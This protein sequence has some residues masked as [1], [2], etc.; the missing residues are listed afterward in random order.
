MDISRRSFLKVSLGGLLAAAIASDPIISVISESISK[1]PYKVFLYLIQTKNNEWKVKG[2]TCINVEK[3]KISPN[4]F[5]VD[6]FKP[7]GVYDAEE[8][9]DKKLQ[10]WNQYNCGKGYQ[11][12]NYQ[13]R[14]NNGN[15]AKSTG[16]LNSIRKKAGES[17]MN[18]VNKVNKQ[19]NH[20]RKLGDVK[21]GVN[22]DEQTKKK[23][24]ESS[25]HSWRPVMQFDLD[26]NFLK[27]WDNFTDIQKE[28]KIF[29][30]NVQNCCKGNVKSAYGFVW[31]YKYL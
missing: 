20:W 27:E 7:L 18:Y 1:S 12:M 2:T 24:Y 16:Q 29:K 8:S 25:K 10:F 6:T 4:K 5:N 13:I 3:I 9:N 17:T 21:I 22:R 23:L 28:L 11:K 19:K 14:I 31:R 30:Q 26:G 15:K